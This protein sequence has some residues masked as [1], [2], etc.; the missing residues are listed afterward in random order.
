MNTLKVKKQDV[1]IK[2]VGSMFIKHRKRCWNMAL[3]VPLNPLYIYKKI[4]NYN[5]KG[6]SLAYN[7]SKISIKDSN[8]FRLSFSFIA[9]Q[10]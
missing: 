7:L 1:H 8:D 2:L 3:K 5:V 9:K 6:F 10:Q 4:T